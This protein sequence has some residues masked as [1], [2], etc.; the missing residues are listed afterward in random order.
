[1]IPYY[2]GLVTIDM[3]GLMDTHLARLEGMMHR[4]FDAVYVLEREPDIVILIRYPEWL[5]DEPF[6][7]SEIDRNLVANDAFQDGYRI[8]H[9]I[10][11]TERWFLIYERRS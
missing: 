7:Q 2:S 9:R 4:K 6:W 1:M 5:G 11:G 3:F 8:L 10:E